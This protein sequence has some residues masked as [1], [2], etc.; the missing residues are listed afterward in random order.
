MVKSLI[1]V[2]VTCTFASLSFTLIH[3]PSSFL[4]LLPPFALP[5]PSSY[6]VGVIHVKSLIHV[7]VTCFQEPQQ[8]S[9]VFSGMRVKRKIHVFLDFSANISDKLKQELESEGEGRRVK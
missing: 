4:L 9:D 8:F 5:L 6:Q 3:L 1:H 2:K 7:K